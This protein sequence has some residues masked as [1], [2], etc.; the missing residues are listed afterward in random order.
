MPRQNRS[1]KKGAPHRDAR[2]FVIVAE[3]E[4]EDGYFSW[5]N[6]RNQRIRVNVIPREQD[7]SAPNHFLPRIEKF[8]EDGGWSPADNDVLWCVLDVDRWSREEIE[9]LRTIC[10]QH[11]NWGMAIS[12]PCFEV[13]LLYHNAANITDEGENCTKLKQ[14]LHGQLSPGGYNVDAVAP[15]I[16][17]AATNARN[18]D[19]SEQGHFPDRMKTKLYLLA[20]QLLVM[21]GA[22]WR[23][24]IE[25]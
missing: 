4:R 2:L 14:R 22:N 1:Y 12:N 6:E 11:E 21:L 16:Q 7:K 20:D 10:E 5:F 19:D 25:P 23:Q 17:T 3:G 8:I 24:N 13:W 15:L 18:A 9:G